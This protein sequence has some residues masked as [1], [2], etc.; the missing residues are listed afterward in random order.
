MLYIKQN[1]LSL[2]DASFAKALDIAPNNVKANTIMGV[3]N[4]NLKN[5]MMPYIILLTQQYR[6]ENNDYTNLAKN[7]I[8]IEKIE[9]LILKL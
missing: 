6:Y 7:I 9:K 3:I 4:F 8:L 1:K 2:A 5:M